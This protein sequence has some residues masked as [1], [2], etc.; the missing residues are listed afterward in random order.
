MYKNLLVPVDGSKLSARAADEAVKLAQ[1]L[2]TGVVFLHV[3]PMFQIPYVM[4]GMITDPMTEQDYEKA[5]AKEAAILLGK[6]ER[7][8][9]AGKVRCKTVHVLFDSPWESII[10]SAK[11]HK[12]D[13]IVM[14]S[15]GRR[16]VAA[17]LLGSETQKVLTHSKIPV[18]VVR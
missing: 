3:S 12:C 2:K 5:V 17:L 4:D 18:L 15:H 1:W 14:A 11:K 7:K 10:S 6:M 16:G 8:A 13:A 9:K